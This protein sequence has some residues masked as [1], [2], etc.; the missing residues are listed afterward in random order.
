MEDFLQELTE[1]AFQHQEP[2][3]QQE[4]QASEAPPVSLQQTMDDFLKELSEDALQELIEDQ[5]PI[6]QPS[7]VAM[8]QTV[9]QKAALTLGYKQ[10]KDKQEES[11]IEFAKGRDVFVSLPTGYGK[12][13]CYTILPKVFDLLRN[14]DRKSMMLVVSPLVALMK[15]QVAS[16]TAMGLSAIYISDKQSTNASLKQSI[17]NGEYQIIFMSPEALIC[18]MEWRSMLSTHIYQE[19]LIAFVIDEAHCIKK[20]YVAND[21]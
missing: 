9:I 16:I 17:K 10:L 8:L 21:K 1:D 19:N 6:Q 2:I 4:Q 3:Q 20:W 11:I 12:S 14:A 5:E 15:D 7:K 18:N 13:L